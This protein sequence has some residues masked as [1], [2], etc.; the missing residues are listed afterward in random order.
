MAMA[1]LTPWL[2]AV[3]KAIRSIPKGETASYSRVALMAGKP[4][5][6]RA[7]VRALHSV[8]DVPWWRV[9]RADGTLAVEVAEEQARR[10]RAEGVAVEGRRLRPAEATPGRGSARRASK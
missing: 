5:A 6:A 3:T 10:L 2:E 7:V 8:R 4:G 9:V 1:A